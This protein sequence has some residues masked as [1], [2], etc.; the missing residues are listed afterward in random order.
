MD[1]AGARSYNRSAREGFAKLIHF[2]MR[3]GQVVADGS[4]DQ[5]FSNRLVFGFCDVSHLE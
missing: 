5:L 1:D 4:V 3:F 2:L